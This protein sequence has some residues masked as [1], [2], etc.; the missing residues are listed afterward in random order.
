MKW[1]KG[2]L[3]FLM[4]FVFTI[5]Q[6]SMALAGNVV[7]L[8]PIENAY[9][10]FI[11]QSVGSGAYYAIEKLGEN[12]TPVL[13]IG[14]EG[15]TE[16]NGKVFF[17]GCD[18]Y[19]YANQQVIAAGS[20]SSLFVPLRMVQ[21]EGQIYIQT[22]FNAHSVCFSFFKESGWYDYVY[23][24]NEALA[25]G[26]TQEENGEF[27]SC[28]NRFV[29][30]ISEYTDL[31]LVCFQ[32]N[33]AS[34][35][36][37][38]IYSDTESSIGLY[39]LASAMEVDFADE[40]FSSE[41]TFLGVKDLKRKMINAVYFVRDLDE[42]SEQAWDVSA[43]Q[44]GSIMLWTKMDNGCCSVYIGADEDIYANP[45]CRYLFYLCEELKEIHFDGNFLTCDVEKFS[46]MF[47]DCPK[48]TLI[49]GI[50][51]FDTYAGWNF[52]SMFCG[53]E[54][55]TSLDL[56]SFETDSAENMSHMFY[57][58][59]NLETLWIDNFS[60]SPFC[61]TTDMFKKTKW[62]GSSPILDDVS[63]SVS[64]TCIL[65]TDILTNEPRLRARLL[66][67]YDDILTEILQDRI[68]FLGTWTIGDPY[69][70]Y[71]M[72]DINGDDIPEMIIREDLDGQ[73]H[74]VVY[75]FEMITCS[76]KKA[77][78]GE[79][80]ATWP[81][82]Y[83][84]SVAHTIKYSDN[85][86]THYMHFENGMFEWDN[87]LTLENEDATVCK[88][89]LILPE[90]IFEGEDDITGD[91]E[92]NSIEVMV[93]TAPNGYYNYLAVYVDS[94][95][96][97]GQKIS[98]YVSAADIEGFL[99]RRKRVTNK[100]E[101]DNDN[102]KEEKSTQ[103]ESYLG[104]DE[105]ETEV[106]YEDYTLYLYIHEGSESY[107]GYTA[108][109]EY[110]GNSFEEALVISDLVDTS[111]LNEGG[112]NYFTVN[113]VNEEEFKLTYYLDTIGLGNSLQFSIIYGHGNAGFYQKT[114]V[115]DIEKA[116]NQSQNVIAVKEISAY[117]RPGGK[118]SFAVSEGDAIHYDKI[119]FSNHYI[120][121]RL[122]NTF[123]QRGWIPCGNEV[124][125]Q[126]TGRVQEEQNVI[127]KISNFFKGNPYME[128]NMPD[129]SML[130]KLGR[131]CEENND[132]ENAEIYYEL[133]GL[134]SQSSVSSSQED[135]MSIL[136]DDSRG[137]EGTMYNELALYAR[138]LDTEINFAGINATYAVID[139]NADGTGELLINYEDLSEC[140]VYTCDRQSGRI[141]LAGFVRN[142]EYGIFYSEK[143]QA[144]VT[145]NNFSDSRYYSFEK[146]DG[147]NLNEWFS[148]YWQDTK[149]DIYYRN[150]CYSDEN[151][152]VLLG[153]YEW[154]SHSQE[155]A[156]IMRTYHEYLQYMV[157]IEFEESDY[158]YYDE[159][160]EKL[161][162]EFPIENI[163]IDDLDCMLPV[164]SAYFYSER[165]EEAEGEAETQGAGIIDTSYDKGDFWDMMMLYASFLRV[166]G[167]A[168]YEDTYSLQD[169]QGT[170]YSLF[171]D[172]D[173]SI[174]PIQTTDIGMQ[175]DEVVFD[176]QEYEELPI[177]IYKITLLDDGSLDVVYAGETDESEEMAG[178]ARVHYEVNDN[179]DYFMISPLYYRVNSIE[180]F[181]NEDELN[182]ALIGN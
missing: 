72:S 60:V 82:L 146:F 162:I 44:D 129:A 80:Y 63:S 152:M 45:D 15:K 66:T 34:D 158:F 96:A 76:A 117:D 19:Y 163:P 2:K 115:A 118:E 177:Y 23:D 11:Q 165:G 83:I 116:W 151:G 27:Y 155:T 18:T 24:S 109:L 30:Y 153:R 32:E 122:E 102:E 180:I 54:A 91:G 55:L 98:G 17:T 130:E 164:I 134:N 68:S 167:Y 138:Y 58:C 173:W 85:D 144:L 161:A 147:K 139:L 74:F 26:V 53:C 59:S 67:E 28:G 40:Q 3:F 73:C 97:F 9:I 125:F 93:S 108:L 38:E 178:F 124:L 14:K 50:D 65:N 48:L 88:F 42:I 20:I 112:T 131:E 36:D 62:E 179:V 21:K 110:K 137:T 160:G 61:D 39:T 87:L 182:D 95:K 149:G 168:P 41:S 49:D 25:E 89:S 119:W 156:E 22:S 37:S 169:I 77:I 10:E 114:Y 1:T 133:A 99:T 8:D 75:Y 157:Q 128:L 81:D 71:A 140:E 143:Y 86:G 6:T 43:D 172:Y 142:S 35:F 70:Y 46:G 29:E 104:N 171:Q 148:V 100:T 126:G 135:T 103:I 127:N 78:A 123:G 132:Y 57:G 47:M 136:D 120:W 92:E 154:G 16:E 121:V 33:T 176:I 69:V 174:P 105:Q 51:C 52:E 90:T 101:E 106:A 107:D 111:Q 84:N 150:Y 64:T 170:A 113:L 145:T 141:W 159:D 31:G 79:F 94:H 175:G 166:H 12:Q 181:E 5:V 13:L 56:R 4:V 7:S